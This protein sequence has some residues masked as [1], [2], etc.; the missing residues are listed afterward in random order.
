MGG[1]ERKARAFELAVSI[2]GPMAK[3]DIDKA[4]KDGK[5]VINHYLWLIKAIDQFIFIGD[6]FSNPPKL[7]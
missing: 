5:E 1:D 3:E 7:G 2:L 4:N 6:P